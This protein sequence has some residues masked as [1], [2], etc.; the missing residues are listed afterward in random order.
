M[1]V[2]IKRAKAADDTQASLWLENILYEW[3]AYVYRRYS[4][5]IRQPDNDEQVFTVSSWILDLL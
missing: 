1:A 2:A 3:D 4:N 5:D